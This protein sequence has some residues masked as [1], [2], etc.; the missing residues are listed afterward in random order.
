MR[1]L[2]MVVL[3][4]AM[5]A[6]GCTD[7]SMD[8]VTQPVLTEAVEPI[9]TVPLIKQKSCE[10]VVDAYPGEFPPLFRV[11]APCDATPYIQVFEE[12]YIIVEFEMDGFADTSRVVGFQFNP[13]EVDILNA[14]DIIP[15]E[16]SQ[17]EALFRMDDDDAVIVRFRFLGTTRQSVGWNGLEPNQIDIAVVMRTNDGMSYYWT[18]IRIRVER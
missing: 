9:D 14:V 2:I 10:D 3:G 8:M 11:Y 6:S 15:D 1:C 16:K 17:K 13:D 5:L 12:R 4:I 18:P 7:S